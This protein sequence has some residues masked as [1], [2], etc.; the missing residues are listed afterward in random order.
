M[1]VDK[2]NSLIGTDESMGIR[3]NLLKLNYFLDR[4]FIKFSIL[5]FFVHALRQI[6]GDFINSKISLIIHEPSFMQ[7]VIES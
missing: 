4:C 6:S 2:T 3:P 7:Q 5:R 1:T